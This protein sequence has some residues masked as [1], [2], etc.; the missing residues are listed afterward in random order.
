MG[1]GGLGGEGVG[2]DGAGVFGDGGGVGVVDLGGVSGG[3]VLERESSYARLWNLV[4]VLDVE[5]E[6]VV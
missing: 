5:L 4:K 2:G 1:F 6:V 3:L